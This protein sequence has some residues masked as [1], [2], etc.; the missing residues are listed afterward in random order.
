[1]RSLTCILMIAPFM[2]GCEQLVGPKT[3]EDCILKNM[4]GI[5]SDVAAVNIRSSCKEK[6]PVVKVE[7]PKDL[8]LTPEAVLAL[9]GTANMRYGSNTFSGNI[10]NGNGNITISQVT[11]ELT[12]IQSEGSTSKKYTTAIN[13]P[14]HSMAD[15]T[16]DVF[17]ESS[18]ERHKWTIYSARG[19]FE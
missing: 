2:T 1:M 13:V 18:G 15:F 16:F 14:P 9:K 10:Y 3:F 6:F 4:R 11:F 19:Y 8:L 7:G 17:E 5:T 12:P